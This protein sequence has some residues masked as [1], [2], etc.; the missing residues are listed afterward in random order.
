MSSTHTTI[1]DSLKVMRSRSERG[2]SR[3]FI[4]ATKLGKDLHGEDFELSMPRVNRRQM[5]HSNVQVQ[6]AEEYF[7]ITI[8][9]EFLPHVISE[10]QSRF[11]DNASHNVGILHLLPSKCCNTSEDADI[12]E[13]LKIDFYT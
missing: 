3:I 13:K 11:V 6:S 9:N 1:V 2:F 10:L 4:E 5:H 12:P 7:R 8:Y